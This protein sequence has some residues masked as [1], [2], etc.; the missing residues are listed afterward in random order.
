MACPVNIFV[1]LSFYSLTLILWKSIINQKNEFKQKLTSSK[2]LDEIKEI[3]ENPLFQIANVSEL[4]GTN[5]QIT[6]SISKEL[7][8][9]I[10]GNVN[11]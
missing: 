4:L 7:L 2:E 1:N 6:V 9:M 11:V 5:E 10:A 8:I 3:K